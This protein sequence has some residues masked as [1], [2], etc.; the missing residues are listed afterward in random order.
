MSLDRFAELYMPYYLQRMG[1]D[2]WLVFNREYM[3]LGVTNPKTPDADYICRMK[4]PKKLLDK[5]RK[6]KGYVGCEN[7]YWFY[8]DG[9]NPANKKINRDRYLEIIAEFMKIE[10][11]KPIY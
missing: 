9:T 7:Q 3:P 1:E 10:V 8:D 6:Q 11:N 5:L 2:K 4:I